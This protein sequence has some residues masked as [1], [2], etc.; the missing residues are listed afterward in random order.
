MTPDQRIAE[1]E[2][3][4]RRFERVMKVDANDVTFTVPVTFKK[5]IKVGGATI[6]TGYG[7]PENVQAGVIGSL[8]LALNGT[9]GATLYVKESGSGTTGWSTTA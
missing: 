1:L 6:Y 5:P 2:R 4:L 9:S 8:Y 7:S 3:K